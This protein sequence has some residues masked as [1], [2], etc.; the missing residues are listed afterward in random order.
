MGLESGAIPAKYPPGIYPC[1]YLGI[2]HVNNSYIPR[3]RD[4]RDVETRGPKAVAHERSEGATKGPR[5]S[6]SRRSHWSRYL[7]YLEYSNGGNGS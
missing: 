1:R 3:P 2:V 6:K 4:L 7:S 5:G